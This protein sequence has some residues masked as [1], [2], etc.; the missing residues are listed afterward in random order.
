MNAQERGTGKQ[1]RERMGPWFAARVYG[2][3]GIFLIAVVALM[4]GW[5]QGAGGQ[6]ALTVGMIALGVCGAIG[7]TFAIFPGSKK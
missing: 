1:G 7:I 6:A 3:A 2:L 4:I 5:T